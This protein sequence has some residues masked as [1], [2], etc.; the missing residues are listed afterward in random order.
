MVMDAL[1]LAVAGL[2]PMRSVVGLLLVLLAGLTWL[3]RR[4]GGRAGSSPSSIALTNQHA[5]HVVELEGRRLLIGTGPSGAPQLITELEAAQADE[6]E[7][8]AAELGDEHGDDARP[9]W[10]RAV[11]AYG[12]GVLRAEASRDGC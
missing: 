2:G 5:V 7:P 12:K 4:Q 6:P 10:V 3:S 9:E 8:V 11:A 1:T